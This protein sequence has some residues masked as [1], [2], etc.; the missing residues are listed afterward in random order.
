[1]KYTVI[2]EPEAAN[3]LKS[4]YDY[5]TKQDTLN[6]ATVFIQELHQSLASLTSMPNRCRE[7][8]YLDEANTRDLIYKGYTVVFQI[9]TVN[10]HILSIFRQKSF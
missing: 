7:S 2:V 9:R 3:D 10:V 8:L 6:K 1:M 5:I 4:I